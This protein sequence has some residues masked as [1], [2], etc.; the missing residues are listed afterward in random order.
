MIFYLSLMT[1]ENTL[2][3]H[4]DI[5]W[6]NINNKAIPGYT[7]VHVAK[8]CTPPFLGEHTKNLSI[9]TQKTFIGLSLVTH[10]SRVQDTD[11]M[12]VSILYLK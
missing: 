12:Y 9:Q 7:P 8:T 6:F 3:R 1:N 2:S 11:V 4:L 5:Q 10:K